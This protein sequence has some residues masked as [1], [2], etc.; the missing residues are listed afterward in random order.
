MCNCLRYLILVTYPACI[1]KK[2]CYHISC[3]ACRI[4][5]IFLSIYHLI[6]ILQ[7]RKSAIFECATIL[8]THNK[9]QIN[10]KVSVYFLNLHVIYIE[11]KTLC[12]CLFKYFMTITMQICFRNKFY[13]SEYLFLNKQ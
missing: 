6:L 12:F 8:F 4:F 5:N 11:H 2:L 13:C 3:I 1:S 10:T 9:I 7:T